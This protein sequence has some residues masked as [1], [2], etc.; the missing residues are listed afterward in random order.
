MQKNLGQSRPNGGVSG[1]CT[2]V[3][4]SNAGQIR[5]AHVHAFGSTALPTRTVFSLAQTLDMSHRA[6]CV[7]VA[8]S[9]AAQLLQAQPALFGWA[10]RNEESRPGSTPFKILDIG[11]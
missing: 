3:R 1:L 11:Q 4:T 10:A 8:S 6:P 9:C 2:D 5:P 7:G